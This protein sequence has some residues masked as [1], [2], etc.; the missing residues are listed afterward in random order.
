MGC[1]QGSQGRTGG[2]R[3]DQHC[4]EKHKMGELW[5]MPI[6][7]LSYCTRYSVLYHM[8]YDNY[9]NCIIVLYHIILTYHYAVLYLSLRSLCLSCSL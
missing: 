1:P 8:V 6:L 2:V 4:P 9:D 3:D 5:L 7:Y